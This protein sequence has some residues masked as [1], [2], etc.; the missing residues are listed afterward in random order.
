[1]LDGLIARRLRANETLHWPQSFDDVRGTLDQCRPLA[2][3]LIATLRARI[4][5]R[6]GHRHHL[7]PRLPCKTRRYERAR[8]WCRL[9]HHRPA[10]DSGDDAVAVREVAR[11]G[12]RARRHFRNHEAALIQRLLTLLVLGRIEDVDSSRDD[13]D[14][15]G[16]QRAV[17]GSAADAASEAG[18]DDEIVLA[19]IVRE[20][21]REAARCRRS[22]ARTDNRDRSLSR[23]LRSPFTISS[24]G[25]SSIS[26]SNRG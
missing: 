17:V 10:R 15:S 6:T 11:P 22:V 5:R 1:M 9:D 3:Q 20:P 24:G 12:L 8:T 7:P 19:E 26:P 18:D 2:D 14:R 25:A 23:S 21:S 16:F 13:P 4:E